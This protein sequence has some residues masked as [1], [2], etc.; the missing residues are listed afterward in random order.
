MYCWKLGLILSEMERQR[1]T[2]GN[3]YRWSRAGLS[4]GTSLV[5]HTASLNL[6]LSDRTDVNAELVG[7]ADDLSQVVAAS[8][9]NTLRRGVLSGTRPTNENPQISNGPS[10]VGTT[11]Y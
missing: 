5:E 11:Y 7:L 1:W 6:D 10:R 2:D 8:D 9:E 3:R 4:P